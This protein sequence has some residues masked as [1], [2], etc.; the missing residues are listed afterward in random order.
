MLNKFT[1]FINLARSQKIRLFTR[2]YYKLKT[3]TFYKIQLKNIGVGSI[4]IKPLLITPEFISV[5]KNVLI[6]NHVRMEGIRR[7]ANQYYSPHII[8]GDGVTFQQ[9]C[10]ITA[11]DTLI[12]GKNTLI[13][14]DVSIQDTDHEYEDLSLPI[15]NQPLIV[16]K[17]K[18][19]EN[20]FIGSGAKIQAGTIL[21]KHCVVGTN[22]VVRGIFPDYCVIVGVPAKIVKRYDE[23]SKIWKKT[24]NK[25]EFLDEI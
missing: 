22:A 5:G 16:K 24:N 1:K 7:Y 6:L 15:G 11:A 10:H 3:Q 23:E 8:L 18:I 21:G 4:I 9:R 13:S 14:F 25:G 20:C 12:I 17:T 19:G 2:F